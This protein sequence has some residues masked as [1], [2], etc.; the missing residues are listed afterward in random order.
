[1]GFYKFE[2]RAIE[3]FRYIGGVFGLES[4]EAAR[5]RHSVLDRWSRTHANLC[6]AFKLIYFR[7]YFNYKWCYTNR[8]I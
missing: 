5:D 8:S 3:S 6:A 1:M 2:F 7:Q 4:A